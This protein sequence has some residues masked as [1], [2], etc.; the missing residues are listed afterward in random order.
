MGR[1]ERI[2]AAQA[3]MLDSH[4][5][6]RLQTSVEMRRRLTADLDPVDLLLRL[7]E[8][9]MEAT[10]T[11]R[12]FVLVAGRDRR[13]RAEVSAG[14]TAAEL[15][16]ERFRGSAGAVREVF[17]TG[18][19]VVVSHAVADPRLG[20]RPSVVMQGI[21]CLACLPLRHRGQAIGVIYVDSQ[22]VG[23]TFTESDVEALEALAGHTARILAEAQPRWEPPVGDGAVLTALQQRISLRRAT[24]RR[25]RT[26]Q[27]AS[28]R[29]R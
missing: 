10:Q 4:R 19:P 9:A 22:Q 28:A 13:L 1:Y 16:D 29:T 18:E 20:Q 17:E 2:T 15:Y 27:R 5:L 11:E 6:A 26:W 14:F 8:S 21:G 25:A 24:P 7:L 12:G 23:P 3:A